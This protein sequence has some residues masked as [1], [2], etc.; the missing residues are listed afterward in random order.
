MLESFE[1]QQL[2]NV[3]SIVMCCTQAL[4]NAPEVNDRDKMAIAS[5]SQKAVELNRRHG[6]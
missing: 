4:Q 6:E 1:F 5:V 3:A 2:Q